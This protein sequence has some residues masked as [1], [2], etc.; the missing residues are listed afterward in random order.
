LLAYVKAQGNKLTLAHAGLGAVSQLC[1]MVFQK[2]VGVD[3]TTVPYQGTAPA[4]NALLGGQVDMLC[5]QTT[6]TL[7]HIKAG[8]VKLYGVTTTE[9]IKSLPDTPTLDESGP[10]GLRGQGVARH[11]RAQGHAAA[12]RSTSSAPRCAPR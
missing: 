8:N 1:G 6:Q 5:D 11:L 7:Q 10:E 4:M 12:Q 2:L 3:F 9:R